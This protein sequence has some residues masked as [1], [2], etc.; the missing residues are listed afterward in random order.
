MAV[1]PRV[2]LAKQDAKFRQELALDQDMVRFVSKAAKTNVLLGLNTEAFD[3]NQKILRYNSALLLD[4]Q[5]SDVQRYDKIHRVPFGEYVPL[6]DWVPF[7]NTFA[8]YDFDYSISSGEGLTRFPLD[9]YRFGVVICY[10]DTDPFMAR[11]YGHATP[12]GPAADF[13]LNISNDG[14]FDG[15]AEH[16]EHLAISRFRAIET[17]R[18]LARAVNMGI[19]AVIDGNGRVLAPKKTITSQGTREIWTIPMDKENRHELPSRSWHNYKQT[20]GILVVDMPIDRRTSLYAAWGDWLPYSCW[21]LI[22]GGLLWGLVARK[23]RPGGDYQ[24]A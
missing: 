13:L 12:D 10:E 24:P 18:S 15:S 1:T 14:W 2:D 23:R 19:S 22:G 16:E 20:E 17:R 8:P 3:Q 4:A 9:K 5:G 11:E 21:V 6:R 7:M